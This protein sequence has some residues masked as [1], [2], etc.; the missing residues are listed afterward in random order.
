MLTSAVDTHRWAAYVPN[1]PRLHLL[2]YFLVLDT[3]LLNNLQINVCIFFHKASSVL[4]INWVLGFYPSSG[5]LKET[6]NSECHTPSSV[7]YQRL[8]ALLL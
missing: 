8:N 6:S 5:I 3:S 2:P 7:L 4:G 1:L